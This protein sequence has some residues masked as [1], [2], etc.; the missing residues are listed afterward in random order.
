MQCTA[1][2]TEQRFGTTTAAA[3]ASAATVSRRNSAPA[4]VVDAPAHLLCGSLQRTP[5]SGSTNAAA[6]GVSGSAGDRATTATTA[7]ATGAS[8]NSSVQVVIGDA[9]YTSYSADAGRLACFPNAT[10][11]AMRRHSAEREAYNMCTTVAAW[12]S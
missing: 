9:P 4:A 7:A 5:T 3:V 1:A 11:T 12:H 6:G 10:A 2:C 8:S